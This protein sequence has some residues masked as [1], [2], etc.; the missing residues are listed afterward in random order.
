MGVSLQASSKSRGR[1]R[2][3]SGAM[4]MADINITPFV[5]V[6]LVLLIVFMV[7]APLLTA[8]VAVDL[9]KSQAKPLNDGKDELPIEVSVDS[10]GNLFVGETPVTKEKLPDLL[11]A[12]AEGDMEKRVYIRGD[13]SIEY[14]TAMEIIGLISAHGFTKVGLVSEPIPHAAKKKK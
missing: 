5:D 10:Q 6:M 3:R 1:G 7:T 8:G 11:E 2:R 13:Q 12:M 14:G 9:P 4:P